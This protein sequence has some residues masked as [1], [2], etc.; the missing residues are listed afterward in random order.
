MEQYLVTAPE[1]FPEIAVPVHTI[2]KRE[3]EKT[4]EDAIA[5]ILS[6][7]PVVSKKTPGPSAPQVLSPEVISPESS[8]SSVDRFTAT[9]LED[10]TLISTSAKRSGAPSPPPSSRAT[11]VVVPAQHPF[12]APESPNINYKDTVDLPSEQHAPV[13]SAAPAAPAAP[14]I[15]SEIPSE[16]TTAKPTEVKNAT[17]PQIV[18]HEE[19]EKLVKG[20]LKKKNKKQRGPMRKAFH[21]IRKAFR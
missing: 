13:S 2:A 1:Y 20:S 9:T 7:P 12:H 21:K 14:T 11:N 4:E 18:Q 10:T 6:S 3:S 8:S 17:L 5:V 16:I 19:D 15:E